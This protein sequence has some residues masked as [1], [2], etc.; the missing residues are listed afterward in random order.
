[1]GEKAKQGWALALT[2]QNRRLRINFAVYQLYRQDGRQGHRRCFS[3][4]LIGRKACFHLHGLAADGN[5][6]AVLDF[7]GFACFG[8]TV[9]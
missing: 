9:A 3:G 5:G 8:C 1:M 7:G 2:L 6:F 4:C